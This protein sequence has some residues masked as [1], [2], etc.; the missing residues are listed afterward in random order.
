MGFFY[1]TFHM[2]SALLKRFKIFIL[3]IN[4][5]I[6]FGN[7]GGAPAGYANN[8]PN[9]RNCTSCHSGTVNSGNGEIIFSG[10]PSTYTPGETYTISLTVTGSNRQGYGFQAI[11]MS[12]NSTAGMISSNSSSVSLEK[13][14]DYVQQSSRTASG[15][16]VFD[17]LA[18]SSDIGSVTFSAS[19][20]A[21][22][23]STGRTGDYVYTKSVLIPATQ[24]SVEENSLAT[25]Y[26][27]FQNYPNPFNPITTIRYFLPE[28]ALVNMF[29]YDM[30]GRKIKTLVNYQQTEGYKSIVWDATNNKGKPVSAGVYIYGIETSNFRKIKKMILLD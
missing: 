13:N 24:V 14:G 15:N 9:Y 11:A 18:P 1:Y 12:G 30:M 7:P 28:R 16:W 26:T 8:A 29:I 10:L 17:W 22:G 6:I 20:L 3:I 25:N 21:T 19:G 27:I 2:A 5:A 23:G 4:A